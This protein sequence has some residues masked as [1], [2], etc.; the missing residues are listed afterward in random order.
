MC[1]IYALVI[2]HNYKVESCKFTTQPEN[3][4]SSENIAC[5]YGV[6]PENLHSRGNRDP[7]FCVLY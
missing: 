4:H 7:T 1:V 2:K 3:E 5:A 6:L